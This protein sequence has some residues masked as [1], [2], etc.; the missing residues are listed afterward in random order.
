MNSF[1]LKLSLGVML[2]AVIFAAPSLKDGALTD[3][4]LLPEDI[5]VPE[6]DT[7]EE[8]D[9]T[10]EDSQPTT[11]PQLRWGFVKRA[12]DTVGKMTKE[13]VQK[14]A[15]RNPKI[16]HQKRAKEIREKQEAHMKKVIDA[17]HKGRNKAIAAR[18][19]ATDACK[20]E[21][22]TGRALQI[23]VNEKLKDA[24]KKALDACKDEGKTGH[25][26]QTCVS[27]KLMSA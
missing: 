3:G 9:L 26:L 23:C 8:L 25:A 5:V 17:A 20:D 19:K 15:K 18:N 27:E 22:K 1:Q 7:P 16:D 4:A 21:G 12:A 14:H 6:S 2:V 13:R 24:R 11:M 10:L